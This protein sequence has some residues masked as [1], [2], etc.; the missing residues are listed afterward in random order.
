MPD[1]N[2]NPIA[3]EDAAVLAAIESLRDYLSMRAG[4]GASVLELAEEWRRDQLF[5]PTA[6]ELRVAVSLIAKTAPG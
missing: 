1:P 3:H 6:E 5:P 2:R 4:R